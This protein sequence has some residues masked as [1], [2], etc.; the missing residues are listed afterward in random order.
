MEP[1]TPT[2]RFLIDLILVELE[3]YNS[4]NNESRELLSLLD[5]YP[6]E[7]RISHFPIPSGETVIGKL[8]SIQ[9]ILNEL[10]RDY[11]DNLVH[12]SKVI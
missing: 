3:R 8:Q 10:N 7:P 11:S 2:L 5:I 4:N 9:Q 1:N 12:L 6:E